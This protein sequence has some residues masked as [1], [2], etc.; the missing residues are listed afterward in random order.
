MANHSGEVFILTTKFYKIKNE[1]ALFSHKKR[2]PEG[3]ASVHLEGTTT[4]NQE[5]MITKQL[6]AQKNHTKTST[7]S[8]EILE[9][10]GYAQLQITYTIALRG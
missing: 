9:N 1:T 4:K 3:K 8:L 7:R 2:N 10:T 6:A 5:K